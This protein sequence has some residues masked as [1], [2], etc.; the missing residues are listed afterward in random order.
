MPTDLQ[1]GVLIYSWPLMTP[2]TFFARLAAKFPHGG[3]LIET[4]PMS[5]WLPIN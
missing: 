2:T 5:Y 3:E 4:Q 1:F